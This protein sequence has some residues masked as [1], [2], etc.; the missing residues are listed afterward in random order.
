MKAKIPVTNEGANECRMVATFSDEVHSVQ[1]DRVPSKSFG[2]LVVNCDLGA[3]SVPIDAGKWSD[4]IDYV[5]DYLKEQTSV[6][7]LDLAKVAPEAET[8]QQYLEEYQQYRI[9]EKKAL[10]EA[11]EKVREQQAN[12]PDGPKDIEVVQ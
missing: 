11:K 9:A 8:A 10:E 7:F 4:V 6:D 3:I 5:E 2:I 1:A 12:A